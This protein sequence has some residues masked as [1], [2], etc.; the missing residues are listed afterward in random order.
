LTS[1]VKDTNI[2][3]SLFSVNIAMIY[4]GQLVEEAVRD[5][6]DWRI[7]MILGFVLLIS[8]FSVIMRSFWQRLS[9]VNDYLKQNVTD[10][11]TNGQTIPS[12]LNAMIIIL[13]L[14]FSCFGF[15]SLYGAI[16]KTPYE[17]IEKSYLISS[18]AAKA[19][20]GAFISY[21]LGQRVQGWNRN[22][23]PTPT[24]TPTVM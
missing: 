18:F 14:F 7:P 22:P 6:K 12:W 8:E 2:Y 5:E 21:G 11:L 19:T 16:N 10:P 15:I 4:T 1:G 20:L 17:N 24:P 13:F 9:Q 3:M 23:T